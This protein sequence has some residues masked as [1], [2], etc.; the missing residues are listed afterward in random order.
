MAIKTKENENKPRRWDA[1]LITIGMTIGFLIIMMKISG[2][3]PCEIIDF[4]GI[5][6]NSCEKTFEQNINGIIQWIF[7][8][9]NF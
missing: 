9:F 8:K 5:Q 3:W 6:D 1:I 2:V 7:N 4:F